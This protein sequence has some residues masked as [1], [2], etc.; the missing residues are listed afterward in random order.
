MP[1]R[2]ALIPAR[3][4]SKRIPRKNIREFHGVPAIQRVIRTLRATD[5][6]QR[7][8]VST[9]DDEIA[10]VAETAGAEVPFRRPAELADS[11][12]GARP[13][14]QHALRELG[15]RSETVVGVFY[16]TAVLTTSQDVLE[17]SRLFDGSGSDFVLSVAEFPAPVERALLVAANGSVRSR[18][19]E[20]ILAR[21]QD[22]ESA[23]YDIGQFYWGS[24]G[25]WLGPRP[26]VQ[27]VCSAFVVDAWRAVDIDTP[28][29][30]DRAE[31]VF[32]VLY[33]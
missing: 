7:I 17:S 5:L 4:G 1:Q 20:H 24:A 21:S 2:I 6:F 15:L 32:K 33:G 11:F 10:E 26:V 23:Y 12:T 22:L 14:I 31:K 27:S 13:V 18:D 16:A 30:W 3:G 19:P 9:D 28:E 25:A 29:D 8:V